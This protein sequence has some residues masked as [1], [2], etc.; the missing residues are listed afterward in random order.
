MDVAAEKQNQIN[1]I[2]G[3]IWMVLAIL[4]VL[5]GLLVILKLLAANPDNGFAS[6]IYGTARLFLLPFFGVVGEPASGGGGVLEV[7]SIIAMV[8]YFL[9]FL[10]I[11]KLVQISMQS[12][13]VRDVS[14]M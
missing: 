8:V 7:S 14:T 11:V 10:G 2:K 13:K 9:I 1:K 5:I 4:E 3:V 12:T 6:F